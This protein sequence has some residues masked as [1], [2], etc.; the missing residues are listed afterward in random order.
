MRWVWR[1]HR[2]HWGL[3]ESECATGCRAEHE[4]PDRS[5]VNFVHRT[6]VQRTKGKQVCLDDKDAANI[7]YAVTSQ[8]SR[9]VETR[10][11]TQTLAST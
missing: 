11:Y 8:R 2:D 4:R 3:N 5:Y 10:W 7:L 1:M 9:L 6:N